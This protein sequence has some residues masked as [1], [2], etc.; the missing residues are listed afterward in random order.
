[1]SSGL[2][3]YNY[4]DRSIFNSRV[5]GLFLSLLYFIE[6]PV[7]NANSADPDQMPHST[8]SDLGLHHLPNTHLGVSP[9][10]TEMV[11]WTIFSF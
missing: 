2:F 10:E 8:A 3:Y 7:F 4:L 5:S 6:I 9:S 1:M 11:G